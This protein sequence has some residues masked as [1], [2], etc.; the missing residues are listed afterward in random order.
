MWINQ[1]VEML[2]LKYYFEVLIFFFSNI[3]NSSWEWVELKT[4]L[5]H[6][7]L[8]KTQGGKEVIIGF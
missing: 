2:I 8:S 5:C 3:T 6:C 4:I 7:Q 1:K